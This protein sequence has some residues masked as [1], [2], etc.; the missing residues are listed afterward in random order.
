MGVKGASQVDIWGGQ[1]KPAVLEKTQPVR[2]E[3]SGPEGERKG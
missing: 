2:P 1:S 3:W